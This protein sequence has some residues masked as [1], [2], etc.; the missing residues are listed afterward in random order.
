MST[1]LFWLLCIRVSRQA[2]KYATILL[3]KRAATSQTCH[4][5]PFIPEVHKSLLSVHR[6]RPGSDVNMTLD[7]EL[8]AGSEERCAGD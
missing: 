3:L 8:T 6:H 1:D 7:T 5:Y 2:T 4:L